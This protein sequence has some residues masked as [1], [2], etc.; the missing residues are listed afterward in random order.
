V[1]AVSSPA[2]VAVSEEVPSSGFAR[3][4]SVG[5]D[6]LALL[7]DG[8]LFLLAFFLVFAPRQFNGMLERAGFEEGVLVGFKWKSTVAE[9]NRA[10]DEA[11]AA[12]AALQAK[13]DELVKALADAN[14]KL[15]D[16]SFTNRIAQ[17]E[18][19]NAKLR[20][21]STQ[22][23]TTVAQTI[24]ANQTALAVNRPKSDLTVG[25]QI[26][27]GP[28]DERIAFNQKLAAEGYAID[29]TGWSYPANERPSWFAQRSTVFYYSATAL[30]AAQQ[31]AR[32]MS[33]QTGQEFAVQRGAGLGVDPARRDVTFYVHYIKG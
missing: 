14:A 25:L 2:A 29:P 33:A 5:K 18:A 11:H 15:K 1:S 20:V 31:L 12:I 24:Q 3:G 16:P 7:R 9:S 17:L 8:V 32:F 30:P 27:G 6:L 28:D 19:E 26:L 10:L 21:T 4:V 22:V 13:N 23:Q